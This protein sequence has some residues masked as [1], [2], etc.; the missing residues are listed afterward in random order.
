G[1]TTPPPT[2]NPAA[3]LPPVRSRLPPPNARAPTSAQSAPPPLLHTSSAAEPALAAV[4]ALAS[5][6]SK[7]APRSRAPTPWPLV[8]GSA[9]TTASPADN[10]PPSAPPPAPNSTLLRLLAKA[11]PPASTHAHSSPSSSI[12]PPL[13]AFS[14]G[15]ISIRARWG[16]YHPGATPLE[17]SDSC[18]NRCIGHSC[19]PGRAHAITDPKRR[20]VRPP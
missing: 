9:S 4:I 2:S 5:L 18:T 7:S 14:L 10:S 17:E 6:G 11:L 1:S 19:S 20:S 8:P 3:F 16:H 13:E 12:R 15:D